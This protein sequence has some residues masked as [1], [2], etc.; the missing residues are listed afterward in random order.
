MSPKQAKLM[1]YLVKYTQ[2]TE[3]AAVIKKMWPTLTHKEKGKITKKARNMVAT[4]HAIRE[5]DE[6]E[7]AKVLFK[8]LQEVLPPTHFPKGD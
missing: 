3:G 2:K 5:R 7:M 6:L 4:L 8:N 1:R